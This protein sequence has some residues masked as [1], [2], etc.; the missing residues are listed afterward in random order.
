MKLAGT[1]NR[2]VPKYNLNESDLPNMI[3]S[4]PYIVRVLFK[5]RF[6][7]RFLEAETKISSGSNTFT[8]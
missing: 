2:G 7:P 8:T 6:E 3:P 1:R 4:K 5:Q